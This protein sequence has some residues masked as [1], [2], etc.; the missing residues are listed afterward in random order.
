M[1][2]MSTVI[3]DLAA[4][5]L[6]ARGESGES[7]RRVIERLVKRLHV[8]RDAAGAFEK[9]LTFGQRL[10]TGS[11]SSAGRGR[12]SCCSWRRWSRGSS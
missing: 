7:E 5:F 3:D 12:S 4:K 9:S 11:R 8:S 2:G 1:R 10:P 6:E